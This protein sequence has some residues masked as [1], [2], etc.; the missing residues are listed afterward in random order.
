MLGLHAENLKISI[1]IQYYYVSP[2]VTAMHRSSRAT[3]KPVILVVDDEPSVSQTLAWLLRENGYH[4]MFCLNAK[5]A[6]DI[7]KGIAADV[8]I[9]D[10]VLP[11]GDGIETA[12][13]LQKCVPNCKI[14][15]ITGNM[16]G[17]DRI[18]QAR[19]NGID[20]DA[21]PKPV[22]IRELFGALSQLTGSSPKANA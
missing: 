2:M 11:D 19:A 15:L 14:L 6:L 13:Q 8:A 3:R 4:S 12:L 22:G 17:S 5:A 21:L 18:L 7:V 1:A 16:E 9:V 20:F 10:V